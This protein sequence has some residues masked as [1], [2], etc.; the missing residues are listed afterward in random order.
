MKISDEK[1]LCRCL[2]CLAV[3][4][5]SHKISLEIG[6]TP[7]LRGYT[8]LLC[9]T[10]RASSP[11]KMAQVPPTTNTPHQ[12]LPTPTTTRMRWRVSVTLGQ[13]GVLLHHTLRLD[14]ATPNDT[15]INK[16]TTRTD[17]F[18]AGEERIASSAHQNRSSG[19]IHRVLVDRW[20]ARPRKRGAQQGP[21]KR[22]R[23]DRDHAR[24]QPARA[25]CLC[26][27][28][29]TRP[30]REQCISARCSVFHRH[31]R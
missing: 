9:A 4:P 27:I 22:P 16:F 25:H 24:L 15:L 5:T 17:A 11:L 20:I 13:L 19:L 6:S 18:V 8:K 28:R 31:R 2:L 7:R 30:Y 3:K 1:S 14:D 12:T 23:Q 26:S 21:S 10:T 29:R